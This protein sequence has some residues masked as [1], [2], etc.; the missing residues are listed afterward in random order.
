MEEVVVLLG[1]VRWIWGGSSEGGVFGVN[2]SLVSGLI[3]C[4]GVLWELFRGFTRLY[5]Q[6]L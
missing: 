3:Y 6:M 2:G 4:T 5:L 1:R